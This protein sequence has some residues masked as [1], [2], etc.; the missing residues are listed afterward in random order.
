MPRLAGQ[1]QS[2]SWQVQANPD[3]A[4]LRADHQPARWHERGVCPPMLAL[5]RIDLPLARSLDCGPRRAA[6]LRLDAC[7]R[8]DLA[9][10]LHAALYRL[11]ELSRRQIPGDLKRWLFG[12][13]LGTYCI[14]AAALF[15]G[16]AIDG[17]LFRLTP[18]IRSLLPSINRSAYRK[19]ILS[20]LLC[21]WNL[22]RD[23]PSVPTDCAA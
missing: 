2:R 7:L 9:E 21:P 8:S 10:H 15:Q 19:S 16:S 5:G 3:V 12:E 18:K 11:G 6:S 14:Q 17:L 20:A 22:P 23:A 4:P 13:A 1:R